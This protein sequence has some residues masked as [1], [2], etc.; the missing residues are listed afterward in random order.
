MITI[1]VMW[2]SSNQRGGRWQFHAG[3]EQRQQHR[4]F[5]DH[6]QQG[7][8]LQGIK[9]K[10]AQHRRADQNPD[11]HDGYVTDLARHWLGALSDEE[12]KVKIISSFQR[13]PESRLQLRS[14]G[15]V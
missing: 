7:G 10:N 9:M 2:I 6:L 5:G 15:P 13:M 1:R 4:D 12:R 3:G 14:A 8:L 11:C